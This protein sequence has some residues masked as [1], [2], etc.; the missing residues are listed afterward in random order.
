ME[1]S[2]L[3]DSPKLCE[4][5]C[6]Q[7]C[8]DALSMPSWLVAGSD[9]T[10][11]STVSGTATVKGVQYFLVEAMCSQEVSH[12]PQTAEKTADGNLPA[13]LPQVA[14]LQLISLLG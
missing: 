6:K 14:S 12:H 3:K 10:S 2:L 8:R 5:V 9:A 1:T 11:A 4:V 7:K 13:W